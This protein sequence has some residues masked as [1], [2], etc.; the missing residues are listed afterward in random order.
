MSSSTSSFPVPPNVSG[1][2]RYERVAR[3]EAVL[4]LRDQKFRSRLKIFATLIVI[5]ATS[6]A[7]AAF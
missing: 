5:A 1:P 4:A 3:L 7:I 6:L 2:L